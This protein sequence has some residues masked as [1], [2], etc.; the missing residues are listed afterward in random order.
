MIH[1]IETQMKRVKKALMDSLNK[2]SPVPCFLDRAPSK[3]PF[4][5]A[6]VCR[7]SITTLDEGHLATFDLEIHTDETLEGAAA[8]LEDLCDLFRS[9]IEQMLITDGE[10]FSAHANYESERAAGEAEFDLT[11]RT[12]AFT[13][14]IFHYEQIGKIGR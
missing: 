5:Y 8:K 1:S 10:T 2:L 12:L 13:L 4:P 7:M 6:V 11:H 9:R 3:E 14:R